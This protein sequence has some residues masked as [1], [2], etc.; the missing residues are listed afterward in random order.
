M[1][2]SN[3]G[4]DKTLE[5]LHALLRMASFSRQWRSVA[6]SLFYRTIVVV[7]DDAGYKS[8]VR[9]GGGVRGVRTNI[10]LFLEA[11]LVSVAR[12]V[13][14]FVC[15]QLQTAHQL[16]RLL[17]RAGFEEAMWMG[18][19]RLQIDISGCSVSTFARGVKESGLKTEVAL[20][21]LLSAALPSLR[22]IGFLGVGGKALSSVAPIS[23]LIAERLYGPNPLWSLR[24]AQGTLPEGKPSDPQQAFSS[25]PPIDIGHLHVASRDCSP[26][27]QLPLVLASSLVELSLSPVTASKVWEP[28]VSDGPQESPSSNLVFSRLQSLALSFWDCYWDAAHTR[29]LQFMHKASRSF[30]LTGADGDINDDSLWY[31]SSTKFGVPLF[32]SLARLEI[33]HFSKDLGRFLSLFATSPVSKLVLCLSADCLFAEWDLSPFSKLRSLSLQITG[34]IPLDSHLTALGCLSVLLL[35]ANPGILALRLQLSICKGFDFGGLK[36]GSLGKGLVSLTLV[37]E[38]ELAQLALLLLSFPSLR[39]LILR[40]VLAEPLFNT[41]K[42]VD[43][44][45]CSNAA[46]TMS[47]ICQHLRVLSASNLRYYT[48]SA[49]SLVY[50]PSY[51]MALY[52]GLLLSLVCRLPSLDTLLVSESTIVGVKECIQALVDARVGLGHMNQI[53]CL[54]L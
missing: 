22:E 31:L 2:P 27:L 19:E 25:L 48:D 53:R 3:R 18:V 13:Q 16:T 17:R 9:S 36:V 34:K 32:P 52:R 12:D 43:L 51:E 46:K 23:Q 21:G 41:C 29:H 40:S 35:S 10:D 33:R 7:I 45:R 44:M 11:G 50:A 6:T 28:F 54:K 8:R 1:P 15:G 47:P 5:R 14:I 37:C 4:K 20:S 39:R 26:P 42:L 24:I 49:S 38:I 30:E